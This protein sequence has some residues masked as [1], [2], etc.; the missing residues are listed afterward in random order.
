[1]FLALKGWDVTGFDASDE[2]IATAQRNA[3]RAGVK[4]NAV[5]ETEAAFDYGAGQWDFI[6]FTYEPFPIT[7]A[8]YVERLGTALK[9]GGIIVVESL[10]QDEQ[11]ADRDNSHHFVAFEHWQ[12]PHTLLS[13]Q[14][15]A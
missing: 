3:T 4:I 11:I 7:S 15:H 2:G 12:M 10:A 1:M 9:P 14:S 5:R 8:P 13:H 6:V